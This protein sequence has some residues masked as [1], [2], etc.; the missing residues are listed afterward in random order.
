ME[1]IVGKTARRA[2]NRRCKL[3]KKILFIVSEFPPGP[4]GIGHHAWFLSKQLTK[5]HNLDLYVLAP[6]DYA[7]SEEYTVFDNNQQFR[8]IRFKRWGVFTYVVRILMVVKLLLS[9]EFSFFLCS[10]KFPLWLI[11]VKW[12]FAPSAKSFCILHGSEINLSNR[13]L[14][15]FTHASINKFEMIISVSKFTQSLLP[16]YILSDNNR[17][18]VI[19]NGL[20]YSDFLIEDK[21]ELLGDPVLL[22]VG[23]VTPRKGQHR[24]I[25]AL[26]T[27]VKKYPNI[28][29][30][31]VG[32]PVYKDEFKK[33]ANSLGVS[34]Y[35]DFHGSVKD[36]SMLW[37]YY[38]AADVFVLLSENQ[39][40]GD[41][42]GFGI[43]A[44]EANL[45][46][47]P[48]LGAKYCGVSDAID[49]YNTG[50]MVDG[51]NS[52]EI[53]EALDYCIKNKELMHEKS[54]EWALKHDWDIIGERFLRLF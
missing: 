36:H 42:E 16:N 41:V 2:Q 45:L 7:S 43:V 29:Y 8:V 47:V 27:L 23:H 4:G 46:G 25:K 9:N 54:K 48:V 33:L 39:S 51:D 38:K 24:L 14:R 5:Q 20:D 26:R 40:S 3:K 21:I 35:I 13:W 50:V 53:L 52:N 44:L 37:K 15:K 10:G 32:Q 28:R 49:N 31:I 6:D 30:H 18:E 12:S 34:D 19:P 22:T 11:W 1:R 17:L